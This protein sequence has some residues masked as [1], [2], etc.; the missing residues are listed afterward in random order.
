MKS[1]LNRILTGASVISF[2]VILVLGVTYL[3]GDIF[4]GATIDLRDYHSVC[5]NRNIMDIGIKYVSG[6]VLAVCVLS[7]CYII[8]DGFVE[9]KDA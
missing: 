6:S 2:L 3:V 8:G 5:T 4:C 7:L 9:D 1:K